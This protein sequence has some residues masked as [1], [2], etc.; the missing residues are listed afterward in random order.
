MSMGR[1]TPAL[2]DQAVALR[3]SLLHA[4]PTRWALSCTSLQAPACALLY[5]TP[6]LW[7][8]SGTAGRK[9]TLSAVLWYDSVC[10]MSLHGRKG[11]AAG[12][13]LGLTSQFAVPLC[14]CDQ[15]SPLT[16]C[17]HTFVLPSA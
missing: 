14:V 1:P 16:P 9:V 2:K 15:G 8:P 10:G 13:Q 7:V 12:S 3:L 5:C 17:P 11:I 6:A 4:P